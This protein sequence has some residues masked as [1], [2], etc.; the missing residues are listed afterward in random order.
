MKTNKESTYTREDLISDLT[1]YNKVFTEPTHVTLFIEKYKEIAKREGIVLLPM[2]LPAGLVFV[3]PDIGLLTDVSQIDDIDDIT[4]VEKV[5]MVAKTTKVVGNIFKQDSDE[6]YDTEV[7][8]TGYH[9]SSERLYDTLRLEHVKGY[10]IFGIYD[11]GVYYE[12]PDGK[13]IDPWIY[14]RYAK[15]MSDLRIEK[16]ENEIR[17]KWKI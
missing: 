10:D 5:P 6:Q 16:L 15:V 17:E 2:N 1:A 4:L 3:H 11:Y 8:E 14:I 12:T 13:V 7:E 9:F